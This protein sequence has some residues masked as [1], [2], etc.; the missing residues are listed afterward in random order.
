MPTTEFHQ[1]ID[2]Q[3]KKIIFFKI[4]QYPFNGI[5]YIRYCVRVPLN[6][7]KNHFHKKKT[8][9]PVFHIFV[10]K[11]YNIPLMHFESLTLEGAHP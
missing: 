11:W 10:I 6:N 5:F 2:H 4:I 9:K 8:Q 7:T 1:K 3:K